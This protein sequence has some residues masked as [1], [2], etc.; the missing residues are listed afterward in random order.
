M[1]SKFSTIVLT[2]LGGVLPAA[3]ALALVFLPLFYGIPLMFVGLIGGSMCGSLAIRPLGR[4][5]SKSGLGSGRDS[6]A[7]KDGANAHHA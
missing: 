7:V 6:S 3:G 1:R 4:K 2:L 5:S